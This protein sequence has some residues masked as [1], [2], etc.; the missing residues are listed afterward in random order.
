MLAQPGKA[1][2]RPARQIVD[3][4][5]PEPRMRHRCEVVGEQRRHLQAGIRPAPVAD[6]DIDG[7]RAQVDHLVRGLQLQVDPRQVLAKARHARHQPFHGEG[8]GR[9]DHHART[10]A[11]LGEPRQSRLG[12]IEAVAQHR[13]QLQARFGQ[14]HLAHLALEQHRPGLLLEAAD[15][16][17]D[18][19][20][21]DRQFLGGGLETAQAGGRLEGAHSG[22]R[23]R[24]SVHGGHAGAIRRPSIDEI[25]SFYS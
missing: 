14:R 7:G 4:A 12:G 17:A 22:Q 9:R 23:Q 15:L 5:H 21:R 20:R 1:D 13:V 25:N 16:V 11:G 19:G 3:R 10:L 2:Q 8:I 6:G 24:T 18:C